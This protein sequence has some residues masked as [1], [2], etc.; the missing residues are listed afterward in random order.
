MIWQ[1]CHAERPIAIRTKDDV[2]DILFHEE[3]II[4]EIYKGVG[5]S[6]HFHQVLIMK[7]ENSTC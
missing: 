4:N 5:V 3:G 1:K 2:V 7:S 6:P